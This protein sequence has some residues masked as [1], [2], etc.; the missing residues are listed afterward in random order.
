MFRVFLFH[1]L[2][3]LTLEIEEEIKKMPKFILDGFSLE[4]PPWIMK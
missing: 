3:K 1:P 2:E 4:A